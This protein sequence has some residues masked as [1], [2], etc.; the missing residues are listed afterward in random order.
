M[1]INLFR[2]ERSEKSRSRK[3]PLLP[4][5]GI[6]IDFAGRQFSFRHAPLLETLLNLMERGATRS[7]FE[8]IVTEQLYEIS[9]PSIVRKKTVNV[10]SRTISSRTRKL[11]GSATS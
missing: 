3:L 7:N 4:R 11:K 6:V 9:L 1:I 8:K 2:M 10:K 5:V